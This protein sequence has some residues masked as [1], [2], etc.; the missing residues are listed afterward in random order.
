MNQEHIIPVPN[1]SDVKHAESKCR[2][3][4]RFCLDVVTREAKKDICEE[5]GQDRSFRPSL[6]HVNTS[7]SFRCWY[8]NCETVSFE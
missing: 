5:C 4:I 3:T 6:K 7:M 8:K 1:K 2:D